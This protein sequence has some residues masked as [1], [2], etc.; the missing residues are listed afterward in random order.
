MRFRLAL[1]PLCFVLIAASGLQA[2]SS[3]C[4]FIKDPDRRAACHAGG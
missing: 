2:R 1:L 3:E 4:G